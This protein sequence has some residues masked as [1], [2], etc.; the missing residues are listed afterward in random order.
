MRGS[1]IIRNEGIKQ[2]QL[3][4]SL[5]FSKYG[6]DMGLQKTKTMIIEK[7]LD[8]PTIKIQINGRLLEQVKSFVYLGH[9]ITEDDKRDTE[10]RKRICISKSTF[11]NMKS[12]L[13]SKQI[14]NKLKMRIA[15]C[16]VYSILLYGVESWILNKMMDKISV[17]QM[18]AS[19]E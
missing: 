9:T 19:D 8:K 2:T 5:Y 1:N 12:F 13:T 7:T 11:I 4:V 6:L 15:R 17:F 10:I 16:Y 3:T 14:T 18:W